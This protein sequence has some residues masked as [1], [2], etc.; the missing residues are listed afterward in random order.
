MQHSC[1][2]SNAIRNQRFKKRIELRTSLPH[3]FLIISHRHHCHS[4]PLPIVTTSLPH[5]FLLSPLPFLTTHPSSESIP[6]LLILLW[7]IVILCIVIWS[8]ALP[9]GQF[10]SFLFFCYVLVD[11]V[12]LNDLPPFL[13]VNFIASHSFVMYCYMIYH[14]SSR[15]IS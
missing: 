4:S 15:S 6:L 5:H 9:Q 1:S 12:L 13:K 2:H 8:T 10:H 14:P 7:C 3:H 11:Y